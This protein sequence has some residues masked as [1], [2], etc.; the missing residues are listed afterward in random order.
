MECGFKI[1]HYRYVENLAYTILSQ[2]G[3]LTWLSFLSRS[4]ILTLDNLIEK[5]PL[6]YLVSFGY[7]IEAR[8][9]G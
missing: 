3:V 1:V 2:T 8:K 6:A 9:A 7:P 4:R 5:L